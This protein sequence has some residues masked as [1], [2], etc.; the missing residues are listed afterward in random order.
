M[1]E[2]G[3]G[4]PVEQS[5]LQQW[6]QTSFLTPLAAGALMWLASAETALWDPLG[7]EGYSCICAKIHNDSCMDWPG[8]NELISNVGIDGSREGLC[9]RSPSGVCDQ[10]GVDSHCSVNIERTVPGFQGTWNG[11]RSEPSI[12]ENAGSRGSWAEGEL[13]M[14]LG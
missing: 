1:W 7:T 9:A 14:L 8:Y 2:G 13:R 3:L 12:E 10:L 5:A 11:P 6:P 4:A